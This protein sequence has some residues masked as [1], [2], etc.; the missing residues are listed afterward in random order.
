[1]HIEQVYHTKKLFKHAIDIPFGPRTNDN[2]PPALQSSSHPAPATVLTSDIQL[3]VHSHPVCSVLGS[4]LRPRRLPRIACLQVL[5]PASRCLPHTLLHCHLH[6]L[7]PSPTPQSLTLCTH[8]LHL[9][10]LH[11]WPHTP[12]V[13]SC[14]TQPITITHT[15]TL[16]YKS[17]CSEFLG[18]S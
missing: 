17:F 6:T 1:M 11:H 10:A 3:C 5:V 7:S 8:T 4:G 2:S 14:T 13:S 15:L 9:H 16:T 18:H 12:R